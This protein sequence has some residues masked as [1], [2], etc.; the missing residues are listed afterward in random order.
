MKQSSRKMCGCPRP[1]PYRPWDCPQT[2]RSKKEAGQ[3]S[4]PP[5]RAATER[6]RNFLPHVFLFVSGVRTV[7]VVVLNEAD[8]VS[9]SSIG[10]SSR[11]RR[12]LLRGGRRSRLVGGLRRRLRRG[13]LRLCRSR[14]TLRGL[15][16]PLV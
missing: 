9:L 15:G 13:E 4:S 14:L 7:E 1:Q 16:H 11:N 10:V 12:H 3:L 2:A 5:H 6:R 8:D